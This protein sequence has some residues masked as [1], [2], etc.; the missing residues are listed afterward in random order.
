VVEVTLAAK[1]DGADAATDLVVTG[2]KLTVTV[3]GGDDGVPGETS[4]VIDAGTVK[5]ALDS[6][7]AAGTTLHIVGR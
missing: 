2:G 6:V 5:V 1:G 4:L 3:A 7:P